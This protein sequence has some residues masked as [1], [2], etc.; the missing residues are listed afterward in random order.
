M[1]EVEQLDKYKQSYT[2]DFPH[3]EENLLAHAAYGERIALYIQSQGTS[4]AMSLGIG[5]TEV[6]RRILAKLIGGPLKR[7][8][9]VDG[10]PQIIE[11]F[12]RSLEPMPDG[13]ELIEGFFENFVTPGRFDVIEAGFILEHVDNPAL[14]LDRLH[15]F[16][17][18]G[19]RIFIAV[20][21]ARSLHRLL[22]HMAGLLED[23]YVLSQWDLALGHKRYFDLEMLSTLVRDAGFQI[24][25]AEGLLLKPF[26]TA[27]LNTLNLSPAVWQ[28]LLKVSAGYPDISYAIYL[29]ATA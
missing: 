26:T 17:A 28:A 18:P 9:V 22:G 8:V 29:E 20:P 27:Q 3:F 7:Y 15:Q 5:H 24:A 6:A 23:M 25:K 21:N 16:L 14:V 19:G 1:K 13:L 12:R 4:A 11:G 10:A 2:A